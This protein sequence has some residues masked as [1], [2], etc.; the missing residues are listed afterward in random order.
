MSL[1]RSF[2]VNVAPKLVVVLD[3][4]INELV[5]F[6]LTLS[7]TDPDVPLQSLTYGLAQGPIGM[8]VSSGGL[9]TWTP[10]DAQGPSTNK[11]LVKLSDGILSV[12]NSLTVM[13]KP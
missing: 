3:R 11:V 4:I 10:T 2:E 7:G 13:V 5:T 9:L 12:T 6:Q 1:V 8:K